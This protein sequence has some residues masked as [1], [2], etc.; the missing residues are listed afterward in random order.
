MVQAP[1]SRRCP[2]LTAFPFTL[3]RSFLRHPLIAAPPRARP[4]G[5]GWRYFPL[6]WFP[7]A[8]KPRPRF[9]GT[10]RCLNTIVSC[11]LSRSVGFQ[12]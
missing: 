9:P 6:P 12:R 5:D 11:R 8:L 4:P 7:A 3:S 2:R 1:P 10:D